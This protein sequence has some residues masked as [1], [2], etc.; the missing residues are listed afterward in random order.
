M[1]TCRLT[2]LLG[3][4]GLPNDRAADSRWQ[5]LPWLGM[6]AEFEE[7]LDMPTRA[8]QLRRR[9]EALKLKAL[10]AQIKV[11]VDA[12]ERDDFIEIENAD[13]DGYLEGL[14]V[15]PGNGAR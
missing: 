2:H 4:A 3:A 7:N 11:G 12:L 14:T 6:L 1:P 9:E 13:L 15:A 5:T 8:L 10:R